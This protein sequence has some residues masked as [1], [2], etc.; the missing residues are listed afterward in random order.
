[1]MWIVL[2]DFWIDVEKF[3][4]ST[5]TA[6]YNKE[7][8]DRAVAIKLGGLIHKTYIE[9]NSEREVNISS[10]NLSISEKFFFALFKLLI[11]LSIFLFLIFL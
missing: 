1:M 9:K 3:H 11:D 5:I 10:K 8:S 7:S 6:S 4:A 2:F